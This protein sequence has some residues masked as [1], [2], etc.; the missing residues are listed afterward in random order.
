MN[1]IGLD[2]LVFGVD[3]IQACSDFLRDYGLQPVDVDSRGGRFEA[4]DGT[5]VIIRSA[6]DASLP[7]AI[8]PAPSIRETVYGVACA[9]DLDVI[10]DE[11]GR[12]RAVTRDASGALHSVDDM[13]F[14]IA[15]QVSVRR[16]FSA[17][18]DLSNAPGHAPQG[19]RVISEA[20][21]YK[22][23]QMLRLIVMRGTGRKGDAPGYRVGGKTGTAEAAVAGGYDRSR[24]V[25]TFAAA[26]PMDQPRYVVLAMLDSPQGTKETFGWK[27]AAWRTSTT[28]PSWRSA[29]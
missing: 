5:A 1:I 13:G 2:A 28:W 21:S 22:M 8:G 6:D 4:L 7:A 10:A 16:E 12:D 18:A 29:R 20:T 27:T 11:L 14:A 19:R 3:D 25:A 15:F 23:R 9:A 17:P 26:F 24:N